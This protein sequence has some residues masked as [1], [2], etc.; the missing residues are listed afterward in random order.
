M[1]LAT[2]RD[3]PMPGSPTRRAVAGVPASARASTSS[4]AASS[5]SRPTVGHPAVVPVATGP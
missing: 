1:T 5:A 3:L 2:S 4:S